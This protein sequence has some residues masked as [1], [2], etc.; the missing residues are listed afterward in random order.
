MFSIQ[1]KLEVLN[2]SGN[3]LETMS[4]LEVLQN[5]TQLSAGDNSLSDMKELSIQLTAWPRLSKLELAGNP[6]CL[7]SKYKDR[8]IVMYRQLST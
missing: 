4:D 3:N 7:K 6:I 5:L 8:V 1:S 2:I